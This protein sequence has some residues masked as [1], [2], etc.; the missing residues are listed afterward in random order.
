MSETRTGPTLIQAFI[1]IASLILMLIFNVIYFGED[2][3]SGSNQI[4]LL[5][6]AAIAGI[7]AVRLKLKWVSW[8]LK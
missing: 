1:P 4:A 6:A 8:N 7:I 2:T 5:L 3:L